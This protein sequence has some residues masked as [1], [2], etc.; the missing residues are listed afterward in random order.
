MA[1]EIVLE[2]MTSDHDH[3]VVVFL[4]GMRINRFW[5][6][7]KWL[8][9]AMA[10][11]KML[12]EVL[13][14]PTSGC[15]AA[16]TSVSGRTI[17]TIQYWDSVEQLLGYAHDRDAEHRPAWQ[18][19]NRRSGGSSAVGIFHETYHV[20]VGNFETV[21]RAMP[22]YGLAS[23]TD[24]LVPVAKRGARARDRFAGV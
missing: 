13:S 4:I 22:P 20:P 3:D 24:S 11:P 1:R 2:T 15:R 16:S 23:A 18:A 8:P 21:Y 7:D 17:L 5:R 12:R 6:I 19:F 14:D 10:M 9:T